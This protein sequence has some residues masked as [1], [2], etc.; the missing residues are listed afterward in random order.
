VFDESSQPVRSDFYIRFGWGYYSGIK[1]KIPPSLRVFIKEKNFRLQIEQVL[2]ITL[3]FSGLGEMDI[4]R[5]D[6]IL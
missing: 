3:F 4:A 1:A 5:G 2:S 6:Y